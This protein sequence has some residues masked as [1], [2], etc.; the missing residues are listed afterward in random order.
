MVESIYWAN[1]N[2]DMLPRK[3]SEVGEGWY[4]VASDNAISQIQKVTS[5]LYIHKKI[6]RV[7]YENSGRLENTIY[8]S[9][10][11]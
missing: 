9:I 4:I 5:N 3:E 6:M 8:N 2:I 7:K 10:K 11:L 1:G